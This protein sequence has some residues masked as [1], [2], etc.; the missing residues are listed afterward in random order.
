MMLDW[1]TSEGV[2]F[3]DERVPVTRFVSVTRP[4][5]SPDALDLARFVACPMA[6]DGP[7]AALPLVAFAT[8]DG[9][10]RKLANVRE[11]SALVADVDEPTPAGRVFRAVDR[12]GARAFAHSTYS[13][14]TDAMK[15]RVVWP[16]ARAMTAGEHRA[17]FGVLARA[18]EALGVPVDRACS[19][20]SRAFYV[21][22]RRMRGPYMWHA[23]EG[24]P[25][26]VAELLTLAGEV[27]ARGTV[28]HYA[29]TRTG[30]PALERARAYARATPGAVA[31]QAGHRAT[32]VLAS[33]LVRGFGLTDAQALD[34]L[35]E[36]NATCRP[37][38][39][40]RDLAR[41]VAEARHQGRMPEGFMQQG[42]A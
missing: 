34:V 8:F 25:F 28:A 12:L 1:L 19:D 36:W 27:A 35:T 4:N 39:H 23:A 22:A 29:P 9:A 21:A 2:T 40:A 10:A 16:T 14:R 17:C 6:H 5:G 7:K 33:K 37:P 38:W 32:F 20:A 24:E 18:L 11:V 15:W 42:A 13:A 31:G 30:A 26:D 3:A 41:K